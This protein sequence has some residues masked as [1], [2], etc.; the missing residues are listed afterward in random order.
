[1][2]RLDRGIAVNQAVSPQLRCE[3]LRKAAD[4]FEAA[5]DELVQLVVYEAGRTPANAIDEVREA[6]DFL[7]YYAHSAEKLR[8]QAITQPG[9]DRRAQPLVG[10]TA[11]TLCHD[12]AV[13][14]PRGDFH[15]SN[16]RC[17]SLRQPGGGKIGTAD[18]LDR[19]ALSIALLREAGIGEESLLHVAGGAAVGKSA[20]FPPIDP[21]SCLHWQ[22]SRCPRY[23]HYPGKPPR[24]HHTSH[25][26]DRRSQ[27]LYCRHHRAT[28]T[29][30]A[31]CLAWAL[32]TAPASA[33]LRCACSTFKKKRSIPFH[34]CSAK[35]CTNYASVIRLT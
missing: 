11:R 26:R 25:C 27:R 35:P 4:A 29:G 31:R 7:R 14:F 18:T 32:S 24:T 21:R 22:H 15:R 2:E 28:R 1:M 5:R 20:G 9:T 17:S 33:A 19:H 12:S 34:P 10:A 16:S 13:E 8:C 30:S 3:Q 6:V 23:R